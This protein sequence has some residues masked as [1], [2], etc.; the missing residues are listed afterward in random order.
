MKVKFIGFKG[1]RQHHQD[2]AFEIL[3]ETEFEKTFLEALF[4]SDAYH[5]TKKIKQMQ[6]IAA[7]LFSTESG[8]TVMVSAENFCESELVKAEKH[9]GEFEQALK[10]QNG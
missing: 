8:L 4:D 9:I 10:V 5:P 3:T 2:W 6:P 1:N 7:L